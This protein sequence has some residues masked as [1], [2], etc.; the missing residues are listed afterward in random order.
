MWSS[1][2]KQKPTSSWSGQRIGHEL[3][4][5]QPSAAD[6]SRMPGNEVINPQFWGGWHEHRRQHNNH[7]LNQ[8]SSPTAMRMCKPSL[9]LW[10]KDRRKAFKEE[11][12]LLPTHTQL[13]W[14]CGLETKM[15]AVRENKS[16]LP[17]SFLH[18]WEILCTSLLCF[19]SY[20]Y[21]PHCIWEV[22]TCKKRL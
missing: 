1:I 17:F 12:Q 21:G 19:S 9:R 18:I 6:A 14:K 11:K 16:K 8:P 3:C 22:W 13:T 2:S 20:Y 4:W 5:L 10:R 7:H 15:R